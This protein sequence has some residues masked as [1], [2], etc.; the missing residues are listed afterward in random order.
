MGPGNNIAYL[1]Q[2][3]AEVMAKQTDQL[4]QQHIGIGLSQY[5]ILMVLE[6]NPRNTQS[7]I[8][9]SLGQTEASI[10]RQIKLL[11]KRGLLATKPDPM[12]R[13]KHIATPTPK[14]AQATE[15][16]ASLLRRHS[17]SEFGSLEEQNLVSLNETLHRLHKTA[18]RPGKQGACNHMLGY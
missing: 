18:C 12:N 4:L 3:I 10:S 5:R 11:E 8:A 7:A 17:G 15:A 1:F 16:A 6:W 2:H 9:L 14:G 13:R